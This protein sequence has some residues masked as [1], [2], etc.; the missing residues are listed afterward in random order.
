MIQ[1]AFLTAL[2]IVIVILKAKDKFRC[3]IGDAD[4]AAGHLYLMTSK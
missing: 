4:A 1:I 2:F 3:F